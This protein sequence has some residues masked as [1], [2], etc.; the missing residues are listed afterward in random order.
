MDYLEILKGINCY[1]FFFLLFVVVIFWFLSNLKVGNFL[2]VVNGI[3]NIFRFKRVLVKGLLS[4]KDSVMKEVGLVRMIRRVI[5]FNELTG[6]V[7]FL[8]MRI[9]RF[10]RFFFFESL[11]ICVF[12]VLFFLLYRKVKIEIVLISIS[13]FL[14]ILGI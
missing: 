6:M 7:F 10:E 12:L 5:F 11:V 2:S 1:N 13:R 3:I 4:L 8:L 9:L 14:S